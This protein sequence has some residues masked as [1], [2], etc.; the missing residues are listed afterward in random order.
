V[1]LLKIASLVWLSTVL[2]CASGELSP[3]AP[4]PT[5]RPG[6]AAVEDIGEVHRSRCAKCHTR[7]EPGA[8]TR[9]QLTEALARHRSRVHLSEAQWGALISYLSAPEQ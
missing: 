2:G 5:A 4:V 6:N 9:A 8:R 3:P 7:V 1:S